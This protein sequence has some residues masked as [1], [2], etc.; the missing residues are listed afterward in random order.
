M[1][2]GLC[3]LS[4][5]NHRKSAYAGGQIA[6]TSRHGGNRMVEAMRGFAVGRP[7]A[8]MALFLLAVVMIVMELEVRR[9][10]KLRRERQE[11]LA[12]AL[13]MA[14]RAAEREIETR[15]GGMALQRLEQAAKENLVF[16]LHRDGSRDMNVRGPVY[17]VGEQQNDRFAIWVGILNPPAGW[18]V[19][20]SYELSIRAG[21]EGFQIFRCPYGGREDQEFSKDDF[22]AFL[23]R[24]VEL[25]RTVHWYAWKDE[26]SLEDLL[27]M[28]ETPA[29]VPLQ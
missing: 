4:V 6:D 22:A 29:Q 26:A 2:Y 17:V 21:D 12:V 20:P 13:A 8:F 18:Q 27:G 24:A 28:N 25:T 1:V 16:N 15:F 14:K 23:Y 5:E 10:K 3:T 7:V 11:R 9:L 19:S